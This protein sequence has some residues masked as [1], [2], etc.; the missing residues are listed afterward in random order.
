[1]YFGQRL[2]QRGYTLLNSLFHVIVF[3]LLA[4]LLLMILIIYFKETSL[5]DA[6]DEIEWQLF[7]ADTNIYFERAHTITLE[8]G[9]KTVVFLDPLGKKP[10]EYLFTIRELHIAKASANGG[11]EI[12]LAHIKW[13]KFE[14]DDGV[15]TLTVIMQSGEKKM[16][17]FAVVTF[18]K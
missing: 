18:E 7:V 8:D 10:V 15:L 12:V 14:L 6:R 3:V 1:M 5:R 4:Q 16:R 13:A 9:G 17:S 2:N 11:H